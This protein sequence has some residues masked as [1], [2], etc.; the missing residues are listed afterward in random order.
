MAIRS[1]MKRRSRGFSLFELLIVIAIIAILISVSVVSYSTVQKKSRD[2]RRKS[3][4]KAVQHALEQYYA[5]NTSSYPNGTC[6]SLSTTYLPG[7]FPSDP[8]PSTT[9]PYTA[10]TCTTSSYCICSL[11]DAAGTGNSDS[12]CNF[13]AATKNYFCVKALQ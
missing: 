10:V 5:D 6:T 3:D 11:L 8:N 2:S 9:Y 13:Q 12:S 7:G 4:M 1:I